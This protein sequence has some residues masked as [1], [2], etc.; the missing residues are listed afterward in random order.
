MWVPKNV[1]PIEVTLGSERGWIWT[2]NDKH[3]GYLTK[4]FPSGFVGP[5]VAVTGEWSE[6]WDP[7]ELIGYWW[8]AWTNRDEDPP[9]HPGMIANFDFAKDL[10]ELLEQVERYYPNEEVARA[11]RQR[12]DNYKTLCSRA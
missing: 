3:R 6:D 9:T 1:K 2:L 7:G 8:D 4:T 11:I 10:E 12:M 5:A